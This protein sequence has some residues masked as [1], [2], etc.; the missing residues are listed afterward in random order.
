MQPGVRE[1]PP[2]PD[3][4]VA[5]PGPYEYRVGESRAEA[6]RRAVQPGAAVRLCAAP[7]AAPRLDAVAGAPDG[8]P[9]RQAAPLPEVLPVGP[10]P[11]VAQDERWQVVQAA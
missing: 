6:L 10:W 3:A 5:P 8:T 1:A 11:V 9:V 7:D 4:A 2:S